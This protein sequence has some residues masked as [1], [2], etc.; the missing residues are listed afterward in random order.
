MAPHTKDGNNPFQNSLVYTDSSLQSTIFGLGRTL[1]S[2]Q[3]NQSEL[4]QKQNNFAGALQNVVAVLQEMRTVALTNNQ[5]EASSVS[6]RLVLPNEA[7]QKPHSEVVSDGSNVSRLCQ[8]NSS[9]SYTQ[10]RES[11]ARMSSNRNLT[12]CSSQSG[13]P[14]Y[15]TQEEENYEKRKA[16]RTE[17]QTSRFTDRVW[18]RGI[19]RISCKRTWTERMTRE[20][21]DRRTD[22]TVVWKTV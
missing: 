22:K 11:A 1:S 14:S 13:A 21:M 2:I 12:Q 15:L 19:D 3:Q 20:I 10:E 5:N 4:Q 9:I 16:M 18:L 6:A 8:R 7:H 17:P